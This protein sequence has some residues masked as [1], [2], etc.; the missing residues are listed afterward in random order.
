MKNLDNY[1]HLRK[2]NYSTANQ[3]YSETSKILV[4]ENHLFSRMTTVDLLSAE[5]Y[6]MYESDDS[7]PVIEEVLKISPDLIL[8][9]LRIP[10]ADSLSLCKQLKEHPQTCLIPIIFTSI[11]EE[12]SLRLKCFEVGGDDILTK[13]LDRML[14]KTR[15]KSLIKQKRLNENL[16]QTEQVLF[17]IARAIE[18][19]YVLPEKTALKLVDLAREFALFLNLTTT[20]I[21]NL[22]CAAYLHD[23]G[24]ILIPEAILL[25]ADPLTKQEQEILKQHVLLGE[26][27][28]QP[29]KNK[30]GVIAIIRHHHERRD[31]SGYPDGLRGDDIPWLAQIFQILDIYHALTTERSYKK[32]LNSQ[33]AFNI[34]KEETQKGWRNGYLVEQFSLFINNYQKGEHLRLQDCHNNWQR[35]S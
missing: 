3:I 12:N 35:A 8:L 30:Q 31:G 34:L 7:C 19:K 9:D 23:I 13:P 20:E 17:S 4:I 32:A 33:E 15:V 25:K 16:D 28:C 6:E 22:I 10:E 26:E 29:L 14:L 1:S 21:D 24:T 5:G 11:S 27:I 18:S 2:V